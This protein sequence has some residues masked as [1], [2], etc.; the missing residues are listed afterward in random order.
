MLIVAD[1]N[2]PLLDAFFQGFGEI[3]R[4][5]GRSSMLPASRT[6]IS[7]WCAR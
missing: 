1:E 2:I 6:P 5:P 3:R 7:C 4:Y